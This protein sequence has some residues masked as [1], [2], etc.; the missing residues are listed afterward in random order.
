MTWFNANLSNSGGGGGDSSYSCTRL[1]DYVTDNSGTIPFGTYT[2]TLSSNINLFDDL[3]ILLKSHSSDSGDWN[4]TVQMN[5]NVF[6]LN[7][8]PMHANYTAFTSFNERSSAFY[9]SGTT[10]S[11]YRDNEAN[12]NGLVAVYGIKY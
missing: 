12:T 1:W 4:T 8:N 6:A 2:V 10:L 5:V 7:N 9:I 11:K 3:V